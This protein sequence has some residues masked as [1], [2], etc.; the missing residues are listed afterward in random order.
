[1]SNKTKTN[2]TVIDK[3][4]KVYAH[5]AKCVNNRPFAKINY[6]TANEKY[7]GFT[8]FSVNMRNG[9]TVYMS[10]QNVD[11]CKSVLGD[12]VVVGDDRIN[13]FG[14]PKSYAKSRPFYITF[15]NEKKLFDCI[16]KVTENKLANAK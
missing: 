15:D 2:E 3:L 9:Y 10:V 1:M 12:D 8:D 5:F 11:I 7:C 16:T 6:S 4:D 14:K 13:K